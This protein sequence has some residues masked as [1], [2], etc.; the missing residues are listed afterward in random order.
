MFDHVKFGVSNYAP[1]Q[2]AGPLGVAIAL[3]GAIEHSQ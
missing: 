1:L 3:E 2:G